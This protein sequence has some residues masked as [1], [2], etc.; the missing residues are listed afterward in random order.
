[1]DRQ[2]LSGL[3]SVGYSHEAEV[4]PTSMLRERDGLGIHFPGALGSEQLY[5]QVTEV[6]E[7][8]SSHFFF[9]LRQ[10]LTG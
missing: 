1:M 10:G 5:I 2:S 6:K 3:G 9:A 8:V 7:N 4:S